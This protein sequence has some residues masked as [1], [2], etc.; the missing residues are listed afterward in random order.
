MKRK[1]LS[2]AAWPMVVKA[3]LFVALLMSLMSMVVA[4]L[5]YDRMTAS[6]QTTLNQLAEMYLDGVSTALIPHVIR[7]D[8]WE[9]YDVLDRAQYQYAAVKSVYSVVALTNGSVL[10]SSDPS[11]FPVASGLPT[12]LRK[13]FSDNHKLHINEDL[14][15]AWVWRPLEEADQPVGDLFAALNI[16]HILAERRQVLFTLLS[17]ALFLTMTFVLLGYISILRMVQPISLLSRFVEGVR[18]GEDVPLP[19]NMINNK[20]EFGLLFKRFDAMRSAIQERSKLAERL[21]EE[22]KLALIG[23]LSSSMAHE[24]NNPLGGMRNAIDTIRK[25]GAEEK[26]RNRSLDLLSRGLDGI[27]NVTRATLVTYKGG[28]EPKILR[29]RD[30]EDLQFLIQHIVNKKNLNLVWSNTLPQQVSVDGTSLR[31]IALNLLLNACEASPDGGEVSFDAKC[32]ETEVR[33]LVLDQGA[34]IP[35]AVKEQLTRPSISGVPEVT[36]GLGAWTVGML[37]K[38]MG[39]EINVERRPDKGSVVTVR[40]PVMGRLN[41]HAN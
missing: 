9:T 16:S 19:P 8:T 41:E 29:L 35:D 31:Q 22:E 10:A 5:I 17:G 30:M 36:L 40:V 25:H 1:D 26:T 27:A 33:I 32:N 21:A 14:G 7:H 12:S 38:R 4:Y 20:T 3:P 11:R 23:K 37:T 2:P 39:G 34:G 18:H 28:S 15:V 6:Q 24:V 13:P